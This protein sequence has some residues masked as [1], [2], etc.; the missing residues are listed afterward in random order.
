M[1][2]FLMRAILV[3]ASL[4]LFMAAC[5]ANG[6][7]PMG[8]RDPAVERGQAFAERRCAGCHVVGMDDRDGASGPPFRALRMR[9]NALSL[10]R[11]FAEIS[12]HGSG[13]MPPIQI[14]RS[15]AEDLV[16]YIESLTD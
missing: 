16:A 10:Q 11:R 4:G 3:A 5:A 2:T 12:Q 7:A 1:R 15:E 9:F 13:E 14:S 8:G 6:A